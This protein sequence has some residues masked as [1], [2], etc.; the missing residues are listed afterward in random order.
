MNGSLFTPDTTMLLL[1]AVTIGATLLLVGALPV[2]LLVLRS[3]PAEATATVTRLRRLLQVAAGLLALAAVATVADLAGTVSAVDAR[4]WGQVLA[5]DLGAW[6]IV[7]VP[8]A[9]A[10]LPLLRRVLMAPSRAGWLAWGALAA[11]L[12]LS[13]P[14][15]GHAGTY[16]PAGIVLDVLHLLAGAVWL[17]GVVALA[18]VVPLALRSGSAA[19]RRDV[20]LGAATSFSRLAVI[21]VAVALVTGVAQGVVAGVPVSALAGSAWGA[22][23]TAKVLLFAGVLVAGLT[24]HQ[25]LMRRLG[26]AHSRVRVGAGSSALLAAVSLEVVLGIAMVL[27]AAFLV[28]VPQP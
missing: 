8:V 19:R 23:A 15:T 1:R 17:A 26:A 7:R 27:A 11:V 28:S 5:S 14:M 12:T 10:L 21:A 20:L 6:T 16:G 3:I 2:S 18:V 9:I 22:A 13:L 4:V 25:F 24:N